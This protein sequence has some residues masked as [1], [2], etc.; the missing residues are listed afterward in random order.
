MG[1][2]FQKIYLKTNNISRPEIYSSV[3][4]CNITYFILPLN[5]IVNSILLILVLIF[6]LKYKLYSKR[7][8][9]YFNFDNFIYV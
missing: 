3:F 7:D 8:F 9:I 2:I 5:I 6:C 1:K 4:F